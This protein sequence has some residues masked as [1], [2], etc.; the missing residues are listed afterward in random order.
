M[1]LSERPA[2]AAN[3]RTIDARPIQPEVFTI[4]VMKRLLPAR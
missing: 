3:P 4:D 2:R 1:L